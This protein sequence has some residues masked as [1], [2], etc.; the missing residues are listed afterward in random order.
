MLEIIGKEVDNKKTGLYITDTEEWEALDAILLSGKPVEKYTEDELFCV[1]DM[2]SLITYLH[3]I[4]TSTEILTVEDF[5]TAKAEAHGKS[6]DE[7]E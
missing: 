1:D 2:F 4:P 7:A 5:M 3:R 6:G